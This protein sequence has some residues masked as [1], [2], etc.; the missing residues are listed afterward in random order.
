MKKL[1]LSLFVFSIVCVHAQLKPAT[2]KEYKKV[3]TT[4]PFSD[5]DPIAVAGKI[6]PYFRFDGFTNTPIQKEWKV[7]ELENDFIK[8]TILPE[9]GGKIWS[10]AEKATGKDF[11]YN[12]HVVKF[13]DI[14]M[15]GPWTSGG[16][17]PNYGII[18]HTPNCVT[19]VDYVIKKNSNGSVSC[20]IGVLDLLTRTPWRMEINLPKDK[21]YF[22]TSSFWYNASETAQP[23]YHWMNTGIKAKGNLQ[24]IYPGTNYLGHEGE[25][26][27]WPINKQNGKDISF[28]ENNNFGGYKSYHVFGKYT[29]FFGAYWH[30]DDYGMARYASYDDKPGKKIWIW[31]LSQQGMIW[32]KLLTDIDGQYVEVQSGR[33]FNQNA[34]GSTFTPFKHREFAPHAT[35]TWTEYWFPVLKTKGF[36]K[37]NPYGALNVK[38]ENGW[39]KIYFSALQTISD[40]LLV[41]EGVNIIYS[42]QISIK[43]LQTFADSFKINSSDKNFEVTI[44]QNKLQYN[45]DTIAE[46]LNR[47]IETQKDFDWMS[48]QGLHIQGRELMKQRLYAGAAI[49]LNECLQKDSNYLPALTD[50]AALLYRNIQYAGALQFIKK[51]LS[52]D[53]DDA[54]ANYYYGLI[55]VKLEKNADAKD[56]FGLAAASINYKNAAFTQLAKIYF[57]DNNYAKALNYAS[58]SLVFNKFNLDALQLIAVIYRLQHN[59]KAAVK[60]LNEILFYDALNHFVNAEKYFLSANKTTKNNFTGNIKN[61][62]PAE[63]F[64]ELA[65]WYTQLGLHIEAKQILSLAPEN[66]EVAIWKNYIDNRLNH[67]GIVKLENLDNK[68]YSLPFRNETAEILLQLIEVKKNEDWHLKYYLGLIYEDRDQLEKATILFD[69]CE[70]QPGYAP[71]YASRAALNKNDKG[72]ALANLQKAA[73]LD[74]AQWRYGKLLTEHFIAQHQFEEALTVAEKYAALFPQNYILGMLHIRT[75]QLNR[76]YA[77]AAALLDKINIIPYEG[78]TSGR[79]LYKETHLMLALEQLKADN[80]DKALAAIEKAKQWPENLGVGKPYTE[81]ID[82]RLENWLNYVCY[83]K[84]NNAQWANDMLQ[85]IISFTPKVDNTVSNFSKANHLVTVWALQELG[86]KQEAF[87]FINKTLEGDDSAIAKWIK[88]ILEKNSNTVLSVTG[89]DENYRVLDEL[90]KIK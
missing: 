7:I 4:Y 2:V 24:F 37:A 47:P 59:S 64:L 50:K 31:G 49:K 25:Y 83:K 55:N 48:V 53:A 69:A 66:Q 89:G 58:K 84:Q 72:K 20:V 70:E 79:T 34:E 87:N 81:E 88:N 61:E 30:D 71:F 82:E 45:T 46:N 28:Y 35:D 38:G 6:Y 51:A 17:E 15:R 73:A 41:K 86:K 19:P 80:I 75:L 44:G 21:A 3:F 39:F 22:T 11:I 54:D 56:G 16:I 77:T 23:Y 32:E 85:K 9:V 27:D 57:K 8:L 14:A 26:S 62:M 63:T 78:S 76:Q 40:L 60:I 42:R 67:N 52:I 18:G 65:I 29:D 68:L 33:L 74:I 12:N 10:A 1:L 36:V 43:P 90:L 5:P 13:R